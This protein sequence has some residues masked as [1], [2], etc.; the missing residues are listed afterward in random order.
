MMRPTATVVAWLGLGLLT[1]GLIG[2]AR[3]VD[4][5]PA[6]ASAGWQDASV[7]LG[8]AMFLAGWIYLQRR[9]PGDADP[10]SRQAAQARS[11]SGIRRGAMR[12]ERWLLPAA[13][14]VAALASLVGLLF[15]YRLDSIGFFTD[16]RHYLGVGRNP[17]GSAGLWV[18]DRPAGYPL[19]LRLSGLT[20]PGM[21]EPVMLASARRLTQLQLLASLGA[22]VLL[23]IVVFR[24]V[25][26]PL[27]GV[28]ASGWV[29][30]LG[31]GPDVSQWNK[32]LLTESLTISSL[33]VLVALGM[34]GVARRE[35]LSAWPGWAKLSFAS[36][37]ASSAVL[38]IS[39]RDI[40]AYF[41]LLAALTLAGALVVGWRRSGKVPLAWAGLAGALLVL[42]LGQLWSSSASGRW[43]GPFAHV[44][45]MRLLPDPEA[46]TFLLNKG[47]P[48][49]HFGEEFLAQERRDFERM[50]MADPR[51]T[52]MVDWLRES[53]RPAYYAYLVTHPGFSLVQPL[54]SLR[55][56][57]SPDSSEFRRVLYPSPAWMD[58]VRAA[59]FPKSLP[60]L[61]IWSLTVAAGMAGLARRHGWDR[62]WTTPAFLVVT[63]FPLMLLVWHGDAIEVERHAL[64][65]S[66]QLRLGLG[67]LS[68]LLA[69]GL[70]IRRF[71][72][73]NLAASSAQPRSV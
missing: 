60:V 34:V 64:Q 15:V 3:S 67:L 47:L 40:N 62:R 42:S 19:L 66:Y 18:G 32:M 30:L 24:Q 4:S 14:C 26:L 57:V 49:Q 13:A 58:S 72:R 27:L 37:L 41:A 1:L 9:S 21:A 7:I 11:T 51:G 44:L 52:P 65:V 22:F 56:L 73:C 54:G 68:F 39:L 61:G 33:T 43:M 5:Y 35:E 6:S 36:A 16:T 2:W 29:L 23:A 53:A 12:S 55:Q 31:F 71:G 8:T 48:T 17:L 63:C 20:A 46:E 25:D 28:L 50:L 38:F 70:L 10:E 45:Y 59:A 69:D